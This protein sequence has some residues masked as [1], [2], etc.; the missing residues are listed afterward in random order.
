MNP[1]K[2]GFPIGPLYGNVIMQKEM[3]EVLLLA[4]VV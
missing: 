2:G 4:V 3:K 1:K